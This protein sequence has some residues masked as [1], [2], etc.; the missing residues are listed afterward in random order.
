VERVL[1]GI[2]PESLSQRLAPG[3]PSVEVTAER[4]EQVG[5]YQLLHGRAAS[6][7]LIAR[8]DRSFVVF[9]GDRVRLAID[10]ALVHVFDAATGLALL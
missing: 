7:Q 3:L 2:R 9:R 8:I 1:L 6:D 4:I 5:P 10:P